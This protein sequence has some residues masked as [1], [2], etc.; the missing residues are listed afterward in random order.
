MISKEEIIALAKAL[1]LR[2]DTIEKDYVLGWILWG[3][4][5]DD[6]L[7]SKMQWFKG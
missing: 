1:S 3:I 5:N 7:A 2:P 6:D 4:Y